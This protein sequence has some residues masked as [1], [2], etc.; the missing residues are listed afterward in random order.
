MRR[1][2]CDLDSTFEPFNT[3]WDTNLLRRRCDTWSQPRT[4]THALINSK[5]PVCR[6]HEP[7]PQ[8]P[9]NKHIGR[10]ANRCCRNPQLHR[11]DMRCRPIR[12]PGGKYSRISSDFD[13]RAKCI[14]VTAMIPDPL[15]RTSIALMGICGPPRYWRRAGGTHSRIFG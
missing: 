7:Q 3:G 10:N 11:D 5:Y 2:C 4:Y 6:A 13:L 14:P 9:R 15:Q 12:S 8:S 1:E